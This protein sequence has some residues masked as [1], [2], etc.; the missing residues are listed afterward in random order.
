MTTTD[1]PLL[2]SAPSEQVRASFYDRWSTRLAA[3]PQRQRRIAW[4]APLVITLVAGI[5]RFWNLGH[6]DALV[7]DETYYVKDAWSQWVLG[8]P[9]TWPTEGANE[10]F[11]AGETGIFTDE[12]SFVVHPPLGKLLIGAGMALFGAESSF[13]WRFATAV[14]GTALVLLVYLVAR[15][16]TRSVVFASVAGVLMAVDG[17]AIVMSRVAL[18]DV[19]LA[20][21]TLLTFWFVILDHRR[22]RRRLEAAVASRTVEGEPPAWG[23][24]LWNRPWLIAAGLAVGAATA[25][26]WSGLYV[27]AAVGIYVVVSDALAR[28]TAGVG[29]WPTDAAFRQGPVSFLL[30]VPVACVVYLSSWTGWLVTSGGWD[31]HAIDATPATGFWSW[32]PLALQNLWVYHRDMYAFHVGLTSP[33]S[34][35]SPA[36]QWLLLVRPTSMYYHQ[37]AN[38]EAGCGVVNGCVQNVYSMPNPLIWWAASA[39]IVYLLYRFVR[40]RDWRYA[41]VLT[42]FA[43]TYVP[44]LLYP[45]RTIFQFYTIAMLPFMVIALTFALRDIASPRRRRESR[46][47]DAHRRRSGQRVVVVFLGFVLLISAF[48]YPI[49]TASPVPYDF[50]RLHNW[51]QTWV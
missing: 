3:D 10:R 36:W 13:G 41:L 19:F 17:L 14:F 42:G 20:F 28:R 35:A 18:L 33:H 47:E 48:W 2:P 30:F 12:G 16:L 23:P 44:W 46:E 37:D 24:V 26:K 11:V 6:P 32:V 7:F 5:L 51:M 22:H 25:V 15:S 9:A 43:A 34:Y 40:T 39:A 49:L 21:F 38:G 45:E 27:M 1:E 29:Y 8:Y 4:L 50:W 31:R